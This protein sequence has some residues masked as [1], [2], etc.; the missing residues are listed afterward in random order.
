MEV[1]ESGEGFNEETAVSVERVE[2][3][4]YIDDVKV[5]AGAVESVE[6]VDELKAGCGGCRGR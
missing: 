5:G 1:D 4:E 3:V 6:D 2:S